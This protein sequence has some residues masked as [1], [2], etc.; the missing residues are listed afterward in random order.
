MWSFW[1]EFVKAKFARKNW[2]NRKIAFVA[3]LIATSVAFTLI[4]TTIVPPLIWPSLRIAIGGLP[5]K[6]TGYIFGPIVGMMTG[7]VSDL[8]TF[9]F[10]PTFFHY[11]YILALMLMGMIP[12]I[13]GYFMQRRWRQGFALANGEKINKVN[14]GITTATLV[15]VA[16]AVVLIIYFLGDSLFE[17]K[18]PGDKKPMI[19]N[20]WVFMA[21]AI[22]GIVSMLIGM[23]VILI[24]VV[25][26]KV[27]KATFNTMLPIIAFSAFL[28]VAV[29]PL[30][31]L[32]D[33]NALQTGTDGGSFAT[34][35][36]GHFIFA[37]VKIWINLIVV[38]TAYKIVSPL[39]YNKEA[40]GWG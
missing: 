23:Y 38:F 6:I 14:L 30:I 5:V 40:N 29:T 25:K 13:F 8:L 31:T 20:K 17:V 39:I 4:M 22:S 7:A 10:R 18:H 36:S 3:I 32:G 28:E 1:N 21:I 33:I 9:A 12:G 16:L 26:G 24:L 15:L 2:T 37:P 19:T 35:M 11:G 34:I 27:R